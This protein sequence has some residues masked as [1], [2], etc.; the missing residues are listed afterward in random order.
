MAQFL[1]VLMFLAA[2]MFLMSGYPVALVLAGCGL[3]FALLGYLLGVFDTA[4]LSA[5]PLRLFG[6]MSNRVLIAV[7]L[8]V[9]MG[10]MLERSKVADDLLV[11]MGRLFQRLPSGLGLSVMFV[12][13]LMAASTGIVGATVVTMGLLSLPSM[14]KQGYSPKLACGTIAASGTLGQIIPPSIVLVILSDQMSNAWQQAQLAAGNFSPDTVSVGDLFAGAIVPGL[15]LVGL[16]MLYLIGVAVVAPGNLPPRINHGETPVVSVREVMHALV[17]PLVLIVS[18]LGAI[19]GGLATPMEAASVGAVGAMLLGAARLGGFMRR[20]ALGCGLALV[21]LLLLARVMDLRILREDI[22]AADQVAILFAAFVLLLVMAGLAGAIGRLWQEGVLL[23]VVET[24]TRITTMIFVILIGASIFS[25]VFRGLGGDESI[26][27]ALENLPG[28]TFGALFAVMV[29]MFLLGFFLDFL[30]ITF[31]VVPLVA[32]VLLQMPMAD[33]RM[34]SPVWLGILMA[35]NLQTSFLTPPFGVALFYLRGVAPVSVRTLD[36]YAGILPFVV[37][38]LV[39]LG[40]LWGFPALA[41]W[42]P[43]VVYSQ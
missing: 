26:K 42:L 12:G 21:L 10:V 38:Q 35:V 19:L 40:L 33:G 22:G 18:V 14:L 36:I 3:V 34:M 6:I 4:L 5:I 28:G 31:V 23:P 20:I 17:P 43:A 27:Q 13:M 32:P 1:D 2:V 39:T 37:I 24:T 29:L 11:T 15:L 9:F 8:F 41:T 30:E 25:L 16:Y 7:P